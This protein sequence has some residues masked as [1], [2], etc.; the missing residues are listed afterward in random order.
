MHLRHLRLLIE[1]SDQLSGSDLVASSL[2]I[3]A[4]PK[5][6]VISH[7]ISRWQAR[8]LVVPGCRPHHVALGALREDISNAENDAVPQL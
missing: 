2:W 4:F 5:M 6:A 3:M 1:D 8:L 7:V